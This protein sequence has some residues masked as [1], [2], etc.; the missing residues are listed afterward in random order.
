MKSIKDVTHYELF[1]EYTNLNKDR[2]HWIELTE[3][4]QIKVCRYM[5]EF[6]KRNL[7]NK[8]IIESFLKGWIKNC[9][10]ECKDFGDYDVINSFNSYC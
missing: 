9:S 2:E 8:K 7:P 10:N 3:F 6:M 1:L 4:E 5:L